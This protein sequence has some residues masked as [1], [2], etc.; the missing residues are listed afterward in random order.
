[1]KPLHTLSACEAAR[2]IAAGKL[3]AEALV[4]DCLDRIDAREAQV[5]AWSH[6]DREAA[7]QQARAADARPAQGLLHG[8]PV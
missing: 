4:R 8:L 6:L 2:N 5:R 7:L 3:S 1:M